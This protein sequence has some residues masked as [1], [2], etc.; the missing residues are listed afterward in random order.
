MML[1]KVCVGIVSV[2]A[3][4]PL[5]LL[6]GCWGIG[7]GNGQQ[8]L[9]VRWEDVNDFLYQLQNIDLSAIGNTRFDLVIMDYSS[10]GSDEGRFTANQIGALKN[11]PGGPK[12]VVAYM[13]IGE[14]ENYRW[15]WQGEWDA[16]ND[17]SPDPGA[18]SWLGP[19]NPDWPGNYKVRYWEPAW[20]NLI[21]GTSDSY[22][23]RIVSAGFDGVYLDIID[24]YEYWGPGGDSG[25]NRESAE[26]EMVAFVKAIAAYARLL[27]ENA[28]FGVFPQ[29][30]EGLSSHS[31]YVT[32]VTGLGKEDTW[33]DGDSPQ[34]ASETNEVLAHLDVFQQA[35]KLVLVIDYV[36]E[37]DLIADFYTKARSRGYVPYATG[38]ELDTLTINGGHE[39][40]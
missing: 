33:Y 26:Q 1:G 34:P 8:P 16:D 25:E 18:P 30:G 5:T 15:Y 23:D 35:E 38:R 24:A 27:S 13:S 7:P 36:T 22:L 32:A 37:Q 21:Y 4:I 14:A 29:N 6:L 39:P 12:L 9:G 10:D 28:E 20:Q 2:S 3:C 31:D 19:S 11:S 17:G 40:D